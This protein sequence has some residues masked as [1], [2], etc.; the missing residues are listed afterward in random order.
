MSSIQKLV[1]T[2]FFLERALKVIHMA[3]KLLITIQVCEFD[4]KLS[5]DNSQSYFDENIFYKEQ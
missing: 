3:H 2:F 5:V 4:L 1:V